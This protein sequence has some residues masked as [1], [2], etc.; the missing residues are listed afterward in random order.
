VSASTFTIVCSDQARTGKTLV[1]SFLVDYLI[2]KDGDV[3]VF[4][5]DC[6]GGDLASKFTTRT[7]VID[8]SQTRNV[9]ALFDGV[10][11]PPPRDYV[12]DLPH[13]QVARFLDLIEEIDFIATA[14]HQGIAIRVLYLCNQTIASLIAARTFRSGVGKASFVLV[15][16]EGVAGSE[17]NPDLAWALEGFSKSGFFTVPR[18]VSSTRDC[19]ARRTYTLSMFLDPKTPAALR[20]NHYSAHVFFT[21]IFKELEKLDAAF[22]L[23]RF[24][25]DLG[26]WKSGTE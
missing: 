2:H 25:L 12:V 26:R 24:K 15:R 23:D 9:M 1:A 4:D 11:S 3:R 6:P 5:L 8:L 18:M 13:H 17:I 14:E 22:D 19:V 20:E 7:N 16:N 10:M 21:T